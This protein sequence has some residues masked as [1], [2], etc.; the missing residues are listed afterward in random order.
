VRFD[1]PALPAPVA[2]PWILGAAVVWCLATAVS[3]LGARLPVEPYSYSGP[4]ILVTD[5]IVDRFGQRALL[6]TDSA[7]L[8][9]DLPDEG[10]VLYRGA[11]INVRGLV[12]GEPGE[13]QSVRFDAHLEV[14]SAELSDKK[15]ALHV[16]AGLAVRDRVID[17]LAPLEGGS[18]LLAGFLIGDTSG[19]EQ[20][21][22]EAM[23]RSGLSHFVAV[24]GSNVALFLLVLFV[25]V[26]PLSLGP[27]R[28]ATV[29]L[30]G[31]PIYVAA[32]RFE[33]SVLRA[34]VM[35]GL[36]M[37]G[38][39]VGIAFDAW[40]L[41]SL[42]VVILLISNPNLVWSIGFQLS[43]VATAGVLLGARWP[44]AGR[45][46]RAL[47]VTVGAQV[48]VAPLILLHFDTVPLVSPLANLIAAPIV[49]AATML[50][51]VGVGVASPLLPVAEG[52]ASAVLWL[53]RG[54]A[55]WPQIDLWGVIAV[56]AIG[57]FALWWPKLRPA[58]VSLTSVAVVFAV[59]GINTRLP[60][61][62]V[63]VL[64]VGQGDAIL[65][66]GESG[67]H[68]LVDGG[69][70]PVILRDRLRTYGV[71]RLELV[72]VSHVH[73]DHISGLVGLLGHV[74]IDEVWIA[75]EPHATEGSEALLGLFDEW[76]IPVDEVQ[77]GESRSLG[78]LNLSVEGPLRRYASPN[79]QSIVLLV[80]GPRRSML[81]SGD[82]ETFAQAELGHLRADVLKVP[83]QGA[84]TSDPDWLVGV[85]A[86]TAVISVGP[87]QFG[88][89]VD[90]VVD[91]LVS[92]GARVLRTDKLGDVS[93]S[94]S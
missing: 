9:A 56:L 94:L 55:V 81:L 72:V 19:V 24:S 75:L 44:V 12:A 41:L 59:L 6:K 53:S 66:Q 73:A 34:S 4:A 65:V 82:I 58:L 64:D 31:L 78:A 21:D 85:G 23:R 3:S 16:R 2:R 27:R 47:A 83:H 39:L 20:S 22:I 40:Q 92:S 42:A 61:S 77:L 25:A 51:A 62:T 80:E 93:V 76:A 13:R 91:V 1:H 46:K 88:H 57:S 68:A 84:A 18:A 54:A 10:E 60:D 43:V 14:E 30:L 90:W 79:D 71:D 87:N 67:R 26:G 89:P 52:L 48:A 86:E 63:V 17:R 33:P 8:L 70:D 49:S 38:R 5:P 50:G 37:G 29:A 11:E 7:V 15:P 28:R 45:V 74:R 32:T 35:A 36:A 69:P